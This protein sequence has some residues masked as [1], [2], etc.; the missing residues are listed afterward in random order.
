[1]VYIPDLSKHLYF[2]NHAPIILFRTQNEEL[3]G[4]KLC[5]VSCLKQTEYAE[6]SGA[7]KRI[8]QVF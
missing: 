4:T 1:M 8:L 2:W 5:D 7:G 6:T 3:F